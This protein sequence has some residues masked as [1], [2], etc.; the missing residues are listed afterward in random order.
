MVCT[1]EI[2]AGRGVFFG[3]VKY[4]VIKIAFSK[5]G[6]M[7]QYAPV[8]FWLGRGSSWSTQICRR[9]EICLIWGGPPILHT[10][11]RHTD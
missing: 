3:Q 2:L 7:L 6:V 8:K 9:S 1:C 4:V 5:G 10:K 11:R